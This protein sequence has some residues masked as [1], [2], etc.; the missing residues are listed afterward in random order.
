MTSLFI[1][2]LSVECISRLLWFCATMLCDWSKESSRY[3]FNPI[4]SELA[5]TNSDLLTRAF[6]RWTLVRVLIGSLVHHSPE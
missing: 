2:W 6:P 1:E 4:I 3:F 5:K